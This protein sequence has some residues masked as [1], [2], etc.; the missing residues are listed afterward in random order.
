VGTI[1]STATLREGLDVLN[2]GDRTVV[3]AS[4]L[5]SQTSGP[6]VFW[7]VTDPAE[8]K[9]L[10]TVAVK[11]HT[12]AAHRPGH[13]V[14]NAGFAE[15]PVGGVEIID[16]SDP[17]KIHLEKTWMWG[18][19]AADGTPIQ[20]TG[21]HDIIVD[22]KAERAYCAAQ[23]QS[24]IW[25]VKDPHNPKVLKAITNPLVPHHN[26]AFGILGGKI[27]VVDDEEGGCGPAAPN[28]QTVVPTGALWFFDA[29]TTPAQLLTWIAPNPTTVNPSCS[30]H[31]GSEIEETG[32]LVFGW[33]SQALILVDATNPRAPKIVDQDSSGSSASDAF[34]YRGLVFVAGAKGGLQVAALE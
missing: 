30:V 7:D 13:V 26:S 17:D 29:T 10:A 1:K 15:E 2:Y 5:N 4:A 21:C 24:L 22:A 25:D 33:N 6:I 9:E 28:G 16:A 19:T 31:F 3:A 8:P 20:P 23:G 18:A 11:S 27:V 34:Y 12:L 14:Y 32:M